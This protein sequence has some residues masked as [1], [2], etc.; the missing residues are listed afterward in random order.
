[1]SR[2]T[3]MTLFTERHM[4][5]ENGFETFI[6]PALSRHVHRPIKSLNWRGSLGSVS[7]ETV[8]IAAS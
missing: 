5:S 2:S 6:H 4:C 8:P 1:M 7:S 3:Q